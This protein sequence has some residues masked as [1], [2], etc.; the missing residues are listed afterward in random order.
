MLNMKVPAY[1]HYRQIHGNINAYFSCAVCNCVCFCNC[2]API[3]R[4]VL[5]ELM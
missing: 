3:M 5:K 2:Q 1:N 4:S